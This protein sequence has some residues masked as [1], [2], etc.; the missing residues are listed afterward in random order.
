MVADRFGT[1]FARSVFEV[2]PGGWSAP[3]ASTY[4][5]H[6]VVVTGRTPAR[7]PDFPDVAARVATDLE[8]SRRTGAL[9]RIYS[10]V[11]DGYV[12]E[13]EPAEEG[14]SSQLMEPNPPVA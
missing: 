6:L 12:V 11:R 7:V 1:E 13:I 10:S 3:T 5:Y 2:E 14:V 4:G 8:V 9:D